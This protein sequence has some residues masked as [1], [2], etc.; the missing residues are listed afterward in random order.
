VA[1]GSRHLARCSAVQ[2][3]YQWDLTGQEPVEIESHFIS[4]HDFSGVDMDYFRRL[5]RNVPEHCQEIDDNLSAHVDRALARIDPVERAILR[6]GVYELRHEPTVPVRAVL[7]EAV[8]LA[9]I[10]G[11]EQGYRFV[12]GVLDRIAD[13]VRR[14][15]GFD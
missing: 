6:L 3:L 1:R 9:R 15:R 11:T 2:A 4:D 14:Q 10:F 8:E 12:N 7:D 13:D 5:I